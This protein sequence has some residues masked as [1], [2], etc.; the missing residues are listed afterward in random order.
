MNNLQISKLIL[1]L[2]SLLLSTAS[3]A[4]ESKS[5]FSFDAGIGYLEDSNVGIADLDT[6]SGV[7]DTATTYDLGLAARVPLSRRWE[8]RFAYDYSATAYSEL[9]EFDL[10]LHHALAGLTWKPGVLDA[11]INIEKF[12]ATLDGEDYLDMVQVSPSIARLIGNRLYLRGA[13]MH[14]DKRYDTIAG[15][16]ARNQSWR[17]DMYMLIDNMD[18]Y[19]AIG[20]QSGTEEAD[21]AAFDYESVR[22]NMSYGHLLELGSRDLKLKAK[23]SHEGRSYLNTDESIGDR[24]NDKRLRLRLAGDLQ[25]LE[26]LEL[27]AHIEH[28]DIRSNLES[29]ALDKTVYGLALR[30]T[31]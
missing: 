9:S 13:F 20:I 15:R 2:G 30:A 17:G 7:S 23:L 26:H 21:D 8:T 29:A 4:G 10:G 12:A 11:G 24:R 19:V 31:F 27:A 5:R 6:N 28:S 22:W 3:L 18:Q 16:D 1:I 14:A 25:L